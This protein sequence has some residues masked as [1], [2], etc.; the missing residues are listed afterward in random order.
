MTSR[1]TVAALAAGCGKKPTGPVGATPE[2]RAEQKQAELDVR[3]AEAAA[4]KGQKPERTAGQTA[5]DAE[6]ARSRGR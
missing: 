6:R 2:M 4:R 5:E 3:N 1:A